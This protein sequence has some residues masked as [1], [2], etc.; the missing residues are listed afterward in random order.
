MSRAE[1]VLEGL[2]LTAER[3][4]PAGPGTALAAA[5]A[6]TARPLPAF[7]VL[8]VSSKTTRAELRALSK[9]VDGL[10][11]AC[12]EKAVAAKL[13]SV[14]ADGKVSLA[15]AR[16]AIEAVEIGPGNEQGPLIGVCGGSSRRTQMSLCRK[17]CRL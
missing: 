13:N 12:A 1:R 9:L 2:V 3:G 11:A 16:D 5:G 4:G 15:Q 7:G 10:P 17:S 14:A 8:G 6:R